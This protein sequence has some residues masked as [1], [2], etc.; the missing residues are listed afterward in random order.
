MVTVCL[1]GPSSALEQPQSPAEFQQPRVEQQQPIHFPWRHPT[2]GMFLSWAA[3]ALSSES[4]FPVATASVSVASNNIF[5]FLLESA[6]A[7]SFAFKDPALIFWGR[8]SS[9][10]FCAIYRGFLNASLQ[11]LFKLFLVTLASLLQRVLGFG[12][13]ILLAARTPLFWGGSGL[14]SRRHNSPL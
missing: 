3:Q 9:F 13:Y 14:Q 5:P 11:L 4:S 12:S 8:A 6:R 10:W 2:A 1:Q 7:V